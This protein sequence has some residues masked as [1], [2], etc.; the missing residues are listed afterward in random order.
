MLGRFSEDLSLLTR[1]IRYGDGETLHRHFT[2]TRAIRR[3]IVALGQEKPE[4]EKL[5]RS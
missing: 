1:A 3:G 4:T 2:R 5:R